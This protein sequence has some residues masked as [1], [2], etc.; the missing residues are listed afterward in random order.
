MTLKA[1]LRISILALVLTIVLALSALNLHNTIDESFSNAEERAQLIAEQ[2]KSYTLE[3]IRERAALVET[4]SPADLASRKNLWY[5]I[6]REDRVLPRILEKTMS[7]SSGVIEILLVSEDGNILA[8][9]SPGR[10]GQQFQQSTLMSEW[11]HQGLWQR[12]FQVFRSSRDYVVTAPLGVPQQTN[13]VLSV[14]VFVS[15][16][17]LRDA[18]EP[19]LREL[20]VFSFVS[21]LLCG[22]L[23]ILVSN[24][25]SGSLERISRNIELITKGDV[26][27]AE[28]DSFESKEFADVHSKLTSLGQQFYGAKQDAL[29]LRSNINQMLQR[30]DEAVLLFDPNGILRMAGQPAERMLARGRDDLIGCSFEEIFP[31]WTSLGTAIQQAV[32]LRMPIRDQAVVLERPNMPA[33]KLLVSVELV[34]H[35][36]DKLVGTLVTLKDAETRRQIETQLDTSQRLAAISR[37]TSGVAHEIKNPLNAITLHLELARSRMQELPNGLGNELDIISREIRRLDRV[38]KT[39]LDFNRP[40]DLNMADCNLQEVTQEVADLVTPQAQNRH[41][42]IKLDQSRPEPALIVGDRDLLKQALLNV[43]MNG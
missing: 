15:S 8:A 38:V 10:A 13:P 16:V 9:S 28:A 29:N 36:P 35:F 34:D 20:G 41:V 40:L 5:K 37:I 18:I 12:L 3:R 31:A 43:A 2:V 42:Q 30:L 27:K 22:V 26:G 19:K 14:K 7:S 11:L 6:V 4:N 33:A 21:L 1:R 39:F 32:R 24:L 17:L 23:A 25:V